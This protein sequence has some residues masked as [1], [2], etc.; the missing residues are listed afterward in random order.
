MVD[1]ALTFMHHSPPYQV[2]DG[3]A[4]GGDAVS[5]GD[6]VSPES[7]RSGAG[8]HQLPCSEHL[9]CLET[10]YLLQDVMTPVRT[11]EVIDDAGTELI[12][13]FNDNID[14]FQ[15]PI[16]VTTRTLHVQFN[17]IFPV[18]SRLSCLSL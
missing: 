18:F 8:C 7:V 9:S 15:D 17:T 4:R 5:P 10:L 12:E 11:K 3:W 6:L 1:C 14:S 2:S 16:F 13:M